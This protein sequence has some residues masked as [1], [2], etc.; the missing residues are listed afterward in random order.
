MSLFVDTSAWYAAA[1]KSDRSNKRAKRL[2]MTAERLITTDHVLVE[3][4]LLIRH[5]LGRPAAETFWERLRAGVARVEVVTA[6]DVEAAWGIGEAFSDQDFSIVDRT[7]F[8]VID[9]LGIHRVVAFDD[10]FA[11]V[12]FGRDRRRALEVLR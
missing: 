11:V 3:T 10:D 4:W 12:R 1:D 7:S 8:A 6:T 2:L 5:R 9:R